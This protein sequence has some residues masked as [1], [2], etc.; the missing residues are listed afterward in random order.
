MTERRARAGR[1][2]RAPR[3]PAAEVAEAMVG[4]L[5][6]FKGFQGEVKTALQQQEERLTMLNAKTMTYGRPALS[7]PAEIGRAAQEGVQRL[8]AHG[9]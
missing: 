7:A 6:E 3:M 5:N 9:R 8:S 1:M 4:F 2:R